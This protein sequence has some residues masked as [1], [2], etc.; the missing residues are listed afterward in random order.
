MDQIPPEQ[1]A[2]L[3]RED[4]GP[5]V[6][7]IVI[8]FTAFALVTVILRF[9]TRVKYIH[10]LGWEDCLIAV[11]MVSRPEYNLLW[12]MTDMISGLRDSNGSCSS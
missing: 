10:A 2:I 9:I 5:K 7:C 1:L 6:N 8:A 12:Q 4:Q 3:A 11:S